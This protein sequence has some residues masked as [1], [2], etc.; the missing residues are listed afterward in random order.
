MSTIAMASVRN[1]LRHLA[2]ATLVLALAGATATL[3]QAQPMRGGMMGGYGM[4]GCV[5]AAGVH[6]RGGPDG[7]LFPER[8][9]DSVGASAE[10]KTRVHD[11]FKAAQADLAQQRQAGQGL[12]QQMLQLMAAPQVDA[13]AAEALRQQQQ[14]QHDAVSKRMLQAMLDASAVL[15]PE[16]RQKLAEQMTVRR[17]MMQRH[18]RERQQLQAPRS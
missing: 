12:H 16:Q 5:Y 3:V 1:P 18:Q 2:A 7:A 13:A 8:M 10:Q 14:A 4:D 17:D 11:I 9:L 6:G 15:T